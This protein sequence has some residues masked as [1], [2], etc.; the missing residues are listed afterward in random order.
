[1]KKLIGI[2][3]VLALAVMLVPGAA[4]AADPTTLTVDWGP[5]TTGPS[6]GYIGTTFTAGNDAVY[7]FYTDGTGI[8]GSFHAVDSNDN[9]Y[10]YGIDS[11]NS[12][13]SMQM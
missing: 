4:F 11:T 6:S 3:L 9:P 5:G 7:S 13:T 10:G 12:S 1:M 8:A 2:A